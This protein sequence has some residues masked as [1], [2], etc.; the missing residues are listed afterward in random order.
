MHPSKPGKRATFGWAKFI[1]DGYKF[2]Q[3]GDNFR[4]RKLVLPVL[5]LYMLRRDCVTTHLN[6]HKRL[7]MISLCWDRL[8][9]GDHLNLY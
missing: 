2:D 4:S 3:T 1:W 7:D 9:P 6:T 5:T 8:D